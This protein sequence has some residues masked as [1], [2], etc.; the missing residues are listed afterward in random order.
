MRLLAAFGTPLAWQ[1]RAESYVCD[2]RQPVA[3]RPP[4]LSGCRRRRFF[5]CSRGLSSLPSALRAAGAHAFAPPPYPGPPPC[6]CPTGYLGG[7]TKNRRR[8][9]FLFWWAL[10]PK[11]PTVGDTPPSD[12]PWFVHYVHSK[13]STDFILEGQ[14]PPNHP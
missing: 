6:S 13:A 10:P 7:R 9:L 12:S 2:S 8:R 5:F 11:P 4:K 1:A 3:V 14:S